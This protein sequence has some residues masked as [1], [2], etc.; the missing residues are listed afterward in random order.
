MTRISRA[1]KLAKILS[2]SN[3]RRILLAHRVA[4]GVEHVGVLNHLG[5]VDTIVDVGAN[6][7]QFALVARHCFPQAQILSFE[8]LSGPAAMYRAVFSGDARA[9]LVEAAIGP[10]A[11]E[12]MIHLSAREDSSSLLPITDAQNG[13]YPGTVEVGTAVIQVA[14]L[15][16][17]VRAEAI[18][19]KALLKLDVQGF[20]LQA[21]ASCED[22]L[23][24]F[25]W[26][27]VECS[28]MELYAGQAMADEVIAWLRD[29]GF[30]LRGVYHMAY[31]E[32]G[33]AV[34]AD[35][36]FVRQ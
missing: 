16:D 9:R 17:Y 4:A 18:L 5:A 24:R 14:R 29:R 10:E 3:W 6:R 28:F 26:I 7:G 34:Q 12:A 32:T 19:P 30:Q 22:L 20:E 13:L 25:T 15:K 8:P 31:N 23:D 2:V 27:Y 35:F 33:G 1:L 11:G 21:L 36:L